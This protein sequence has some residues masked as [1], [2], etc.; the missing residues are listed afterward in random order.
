M[1]PEQSYHADRLRYVWLCWTLE[2]IFLLCS[3]V[4]FHAFAGNPFYSLGVD[5][6]QWLPFALQFPQW[7]SQHSWLG[8]MPDIGLLLSAL[9]LIR[10][11]ASQRIT[12]LQCIVSFLFYCTLTGY[13]GHRNF[14]T[15]MFLVFIPFVFRTA[16][17]R[18]L[19]FEALR[20]FLLFFYVSAG[21]FKLV[22]GHLFDTSQMHS[23]L[24]QQLLP[25]YV[26]NSSNFRVGINQFLL[27][28]A[29]LAQTL[30][31][32]SFVA[33]MAALIGFFTRR[34]DRW[35]LLAL[36]VF[37]LCNWVL[38][39]IAPIGHIAFLFLLWI[40]R[41]PVEPGTMKTRTGE[42]S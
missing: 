23:I 18:S 11:P 14:Q 29:T 28:Q 41:N 4:G 26:E 24:Q 5:P 31:V 6:L 30:Y 7:L 38:M 2:W 15:G 9:W 10:F 39:D 34:F 16:L 36:L 40:S 32:L 8:W 27:K 1:I 19:A 12:R 22:N 33:E 25:Y 21:W 17:N 3:G 13:L 37:H 42:S 35:I 20:Y